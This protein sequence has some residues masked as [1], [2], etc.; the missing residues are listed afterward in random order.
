MKRGTPVKCTRCGGRHTGRI[1]SVLMSGQVYEVAWDCRN[2]Q[3]GH[4]DNKAP[5]FP[6]DFMAAHAREVAQ[7]RAG[8]IQP[9]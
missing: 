1:V 8:A 7:V 3:V 9:A 2:R 5:M 6:P 4:R